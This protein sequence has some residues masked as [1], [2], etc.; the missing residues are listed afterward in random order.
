[1]SAIRQPPLH[2]PA[3]VLRHFVAA[4]APEV[5]RLNGEGSTRRWLPSRVYADL[6]QAEAAVGYLIR[7]YASP[8]D[9][10]IG[11]YVLGIEQRTTARLLGHVGFS[12]L[13]DDVEVSYAIAE[14]ARGYG[15]GAEALSH[16]CNWI[17]GAFALR[18]LVAATAAANAASRRVLERAGFVHQRDEVMRFQGIDQGVSRYAW[19]ADAAGRNPA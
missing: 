7:S 17:A 19:H 9:P 14:T 2:T 11:P 8:G 12:P 3:L 1:M 10:R 15:Y 18:R 4:D 6:A 16:A 5:M 13:D